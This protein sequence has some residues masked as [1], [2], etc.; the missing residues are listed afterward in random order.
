MVALGA[1][2]LTALAAAPA[3]R[4]EAPDKTQALPAFPAAEGWGCDTPG[5]R[6]GKVMIVRNLNP[7]GPGSLQ[8][9]CAAAG[10]RIVVFA[11]SGVIRGTITIEHPSITIAGQTA[12]GAGVTIE[13]MLVSKEGISD[14]V[15][16]HLRVRPRPSAETFAGAEGEKV[17]RRLHECGLA[18]PYLTAAQKVFDVAAVRAQPN[19]YHHALV[20]NGVT[21]LVLDHVT[22][23]WGADEVVSL[24]RSKHVTVQWCTIEEGATKEGRKYSGIHN[25]GLFSAYNVEGDFV[26]VH[27][28]LFANNSR[29]NPSVRDGFADI[30][31]NVVYNFRGGIDHDGS[32]ASTGASHDYNY[33]GNVF[34][35]GPN[36]RGVLPGVSWGNNK[37][38]W[39][40]FRRETR[41]DRGKSKYFVEDNL[42][43]GQPPPLP[44]HIEDGTCRLKAP[45][46]A[47]KV[48]THKPT[49]A[50]ERV[51]AEAGAFPR[52]AVT[53][54]TIEEVRAGTGDWGRREPGGGLMA[55]LKPTEAPLDTDRDGMPDEWEKSSG[56]D[57]KGDD[58][59]K[60]M[61]GGYTAIEAY[62]NQRADSLA[63]Q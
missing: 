2:A 26:T 47:P 37:L 23:S 35:T 60:T 30:R 62:V 50:Y 25:F 3:G 32:C 45:M 41:P 11:A 59:S 54:R 8:E 61:P 56:L 57:P 16:R 22:A 49:E 36:S 38:W 52:D 42:L 55:G 5:G 46:P 63:K 14:V 9:A 58:S 20:L 19:E 21:R 17:A 6:G 27:H 53:R 34:K 28:N 10:P 13:G 51:L 18:N 29:R 12:P 1:A 31:N 4:A 24:C 39:A 43:D 7:D 40:E 44:P 15:V 48:T 33:V